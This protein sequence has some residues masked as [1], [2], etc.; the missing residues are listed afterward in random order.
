ME[1]I[2]VMVNG[3][4]SLQTEQDF[5]DRVFKALGSNR[6]L[7]GHML[8]FNS[9][10]GFSAMLSPTMKADTEKLLG[11]VKDR[12]VLVLGCGIDIAAIWFAQHQAYV[13][14]MDLSPEAVAIQTAWI[15]EQRLQHINVFVADAHHMPLAAH[16]YDIIYGNAI[17]HH[18]DTPTIAG[19]VARLLAPGGIAIFRDVLQGNAIIRAFRKLTPSLRT[20]DE[21][22]I[23]DTDI[24]IFRS[25]F[26]HVEVRYYVLS[27]L[28]YHFTQRAI[29]TI[30]DHFH[31][32]FHVPRNYRLC[33]WAD[34]LD[35]RV[36]RH[37]P[38]LSRFAWQ[39]LIVMRNPAVP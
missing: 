38:F 37:A 5:H 39:C 23:T 17:L 18:L 19:E 22:P 20:P 7:F 2:I 31:S 8:S 30:L 25:S 21:H 36:F 24:Q 29:T 14:T 34:R 32:K 26:S 33:A 1:R 12:R 9:P 11:N 15:T 27:V 35:Q 16:S 3:H 4:D 13:D 10:I 28:P 6:Q